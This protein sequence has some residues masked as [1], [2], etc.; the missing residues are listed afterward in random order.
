MLRAIMDISAPVTS[1]GSPVFTGAG[2]TEPPSRVIVSQT[3]AGK[4]SR[5]LKLARLEGSTT[6]KN[7]PGD[8]RKLVSERDCQHLVMRP[9]LG[10]LDPRF[11]PMARPDQH[12]P[13]RLHEEDAQGSIAALGYLAEDLRS[14]VEI[15]LGTR[16][17]HAAKSRPL[18]KAS[19]IPIAATMA[20]EIIGPMSGMLMS[21]SHPQTRFASSSISLDSPSIRSMRGESVSEGVARMQHREAMRLEG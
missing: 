10:S 3:S 15:C 4:R 2:K 13:C 6:G 5:D 8:A 14:P 16:P 11:E 21:R 19:P 12:D 17:S 18:A 1:L 20:L 9:L 7:T